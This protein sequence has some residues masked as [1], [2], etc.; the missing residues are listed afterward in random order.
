MFKILIAEL[1]K[2]IE[3]QRTENARLYNMIP[4]ATQEDP[5]NRK[6]EP[7][8]NE[9][10]EGSRKLKEMLRELNKLKDAQRAYT[11]K[12]S[13]QQPESACR[14]ITSSTYL[15]TDKKMQKK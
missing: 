13:A 4:I 11:V 6:A 1:V 10:R 12:P 3:V 14:E 9:W 7:I 5:L 2:N 15:R 8:L